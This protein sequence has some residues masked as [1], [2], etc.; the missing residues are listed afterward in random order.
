VSQ[1]GEFT[2]VFAVNT[3][4]PFK[5]LQ[6]IIDFARSSP[7][8][9]NIGT[10]SIGS[11]QNFSAELLKSMA[12]LSFQIIPFKTSPDVVV[13]LLR[14]DIDMMIDFPVSIESQIEEGSIRYLATTSR[15]RSSFVP[16]L[17]TVDESGVAGYETTSWNGVF[18]PKATPQD[19]IDAING[20]IRKALASP[21]LIAK[22]KKIGITAQASSPDQLRS[23]L[24]A[25]I[26]KW[27]A[28]RVK[29]GI[30]KN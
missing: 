9:L 12:G 29:S 3:K 5:T 17:P 2:L 15:Q 20:A 8:K 11:T 23:K 28:V 6:D 21:D 7:G 13:A 25:D 24:E 22:F 30:P 1:V 19:I 4:S 10:V 26:A 14:G 16:T 27:E 18:A